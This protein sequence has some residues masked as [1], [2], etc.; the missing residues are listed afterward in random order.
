[1]GEAFDAACTQLQNNNLSDLVCETFAEGIIGAAK[2]GERD[3]HRLCSVAIAA[4]K[5]EL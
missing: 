5:R 4:V 1:M 3:P 2:R